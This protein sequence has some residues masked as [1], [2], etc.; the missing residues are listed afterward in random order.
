MDFYNQTLNE[1]GLFEDYIQDE[2]D[3][4]RGRVLSYISLSKVVPN[5]DEDEWSL[6]M[7]RTRDSFILE[8]PRVDGPLS[9]LRVAVGDAAGR[10]NREKDDDEEGRA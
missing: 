4:E 10:W 3:Y 9:G 8:G 2:E 7:Q 5:G 6:T 1:I